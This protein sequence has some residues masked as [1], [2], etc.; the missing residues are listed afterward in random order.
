MKGLI[1][2]KLHE[3][4]LTQDELET[5]IVSA[6][7]ITNSRPYLPIHSTDPDAICPLTPGHFLIGRPLMAL[8]QRVNE[9][10]KIQN[11]RHWELVKRMEA[12][13]WRQFQKEYLPQ[14]ASRAKEM[15]SQDNL[16]VN[17]VVLISNQQTKRNQWPLG[18]VTAVYPS[19][20]GLV[21]TADITT[22]RHSADRHDVT[23]KICKR[24]IR[25]L[26]KMPVDVT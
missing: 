2:Q 13:H 24:S 16:Q 26:V 14:L 1:R 23:Q 9:H 21:R 7:A 12:Q 18:R 25:H 5:L 10:D 22:V 3:L 19:P 15:V 17:D 11:V 6:E 8:P 4:N 20:D